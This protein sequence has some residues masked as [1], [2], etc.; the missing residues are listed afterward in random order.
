M[1]LC[2]SADVT[3]VKR[4]GIDA[5]GVVVTAESGLLTSTPSPKHEENPRRLSKE[6]SAVDRYSVAV[7]V[8]GCEIEKIGLTITAVA[9][10]EVQYPLLRYCDARSYAVKSKNTSRLLALK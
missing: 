4:L 3:R 1:K 8:A 2:F 10:V 5:F 9:R 6:D 7:T